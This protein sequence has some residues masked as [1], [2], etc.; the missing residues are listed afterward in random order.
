MTRLTIRLL[1][2]FR[3]DIDGRPLT[4]F[5]TNKVRGL[6]AYLA[7]EGQ[8]PLRR[9]SLAGMF[10]PEYT[11][12]RARANLSQ[13]LFLLRRNLGD[14]TAVQPF[15]II[16]RET[17]QLNPNSGIWLDVNL[18]RSCIRANKQAASRQEID[19]LK[20]AVSLYQGEFLEGFSLN[21]SS[22]FE[23][24]CLS[25]GEDLRRL[26]SDALTRLVDYYERETAFEAAL[27][28]ARQLLELNPWHEDAHTAVMRLLALCGWRSEAIL[29]YDN[30]R[31]M[32]QE[33]LGI[34][35]MP[36]TTMLFEAIRDG[37]F[38]KGDLL[39]NG[40]IQ[41]ALVTPSFLSAAVSAA[42]AHIFVGRKQELAWLNQK[43]ARVLSGSGQVVFVTG[44]AGSGKTVLI[45]EF[46]R[47]A[48]AQYAGLL[49]ASGKGTAYTGLGDPYAA[50]REI[51]SQLSGDVASRWAAGTISQIEALRLWRTL[52]LAVHTLVHNAPDLIGTFVNG[53]NL[54]ERAT[55]YVQ[56]TRVAESGAPWLAQLET[57]TA[58]NAATSGAMGTNQNVLFAQVTRLLSAL[59][60]H[61]PLLLILDDL[62]WAD[63]GTIALLFHISRHLSGQPILLLGAFRPEEVTVVR[64][65][66]RHPLAPVTHEMQ[67]DFGDIF[68]DLGQTADRA[69]VEALVDS[70]PNDLDAAFRDRLF[71]QTG[72]HALYTAEL[73]RGLQERGDLHQDGQGRWVEGT[74]LDWDTLPPR[75]E[76]VIAERV[77]RI[78][79]RM[80]HLLQAASVQ[81][82]AFIAEVAA[83]AVGADED[84]VLPAL[85]T[86]LSRD[87]RLVRAQS[88]E[89]TGDGHKHLSVYQFH[90]FLFQK[91]LYN[92]LD[93]VTR[94][95]LHEVTGEMMI[96]QFGAQ[97]AE[98]AVR[99]AR[100]FE[101]AKIVDKAVHYR[102][103]A[104][105]YAIKLGAL[106]EAVEHFS[107]GLALLAL[108][109]K[110][111][112]ETV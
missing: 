68:L 81:G 23:G 96:L 67:R 82:E 17:I 79:P 56:E 55:N 47:Q 25:V 36:Q 73:L 95:H 99:L 100:H 110:R 46:A 65:G 60:L 38:R 92:S 51:V 35:P 86:V 21:G 63:V 54:Q 33:N 45:Q 64:D 32:L 102:L 66:Q 31:H 80:Q 112:S 19:E 89:R 108:L 28:Y 5:K 44:E 91:Y 74:A 39:D 77:Q 62:Q 15:L 30:C 98:I 6:L 103:Q 29:Q 14:D 71:R 24:W 8:R 10:W 37:R 111:H 4:N 76:G 34:A 75:V 43:L 88:F 9:E 42:Q 61:S 53:A 7:V 87:H 78:P 69:F 59:A 105:Y 50:F 106:D 85:G 58:H 52:P 93:A 109:K 107:K 41:P 83:Q 97:T 70:E 11:E 13:A 3:V 22:P 104:G 48:L 20:T 18:F 49:V 84:E 27:P 16:E 94:A 26:M 57:L 40:L 72:G 12:R 101:Q 1:G 90:H 2:P